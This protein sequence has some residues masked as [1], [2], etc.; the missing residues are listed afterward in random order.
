MAFVVPEFP[1]AVDIYTGPFSTRVLRVSTVCNLAL[2][3]RGTIGALQ[4]VSPGA[5]FTGPMYVLFPRGTDVRD[6]AG[7]NTDEDLLDIPAGSGRWY[8]V[9]LVDD[10]GK[11]FANEHR[12]A[13][14]SKASGAFDPAAFGAMRWPTPLT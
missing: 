2:G 9:Q 5:P 10:V 11:G 14:V 8:F 4:D 13:A 1:L 7:T 3:R 6:L 12:Y